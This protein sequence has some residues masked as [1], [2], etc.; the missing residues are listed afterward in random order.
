MQESGATE[1]FAAFA[2]LPMQHPKDAAAELRYCVRHLGF[3]GALI[4]GT[5]CDKFLDEAEFEPLLAE[6]ERLCVPLY[7]HPAPPPEGVAQ[8][9]Y[10]PTERLSEFASQQLSEAVFGW[11]AEVA[12]HV[13]RLCISGTLDRHPR[14]Q[15]IIGHNGETLPMMLYRADTFT[16]PLHLSR[17]VSQMLREQCSV[18]LSGI[19]TLPPL[20]CA[21]ATFGAD[22]VMWSCDY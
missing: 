3:V 16:V 11:H 21:L 9:Y 17:P 20:Q 4:N 2:H 8:I 18:T 1:R 10:K 14:L 13:L 19:F 6:A 5:T 22:R 15:L 7:L 12:I